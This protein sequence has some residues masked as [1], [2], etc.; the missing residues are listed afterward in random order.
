M[1][2]IRMGGSGA[3]KAK[4]MAAAIG[5]RAP[6]ASLDRRGAIPHALAQFRRSV[7]AFY[8]GQRLSTID[9]ISERSRSATLR[10]VCPNVIHHFFYS[11]LLAMNVYT[12]ITTEA[13]RRIE[14][15]GGFDEYVMSLPEELCGNEHAKMYRRMI[16]AAFV[17]E[18]DSLR[19]LDL[20]LSSKY[21]ED[22]KR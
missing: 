9:R 7:P 15:A 14:R 22:Y 19:K 4:L 16:K 8:H 6:L 20:E 18:R 10:V 5:S 3:K 12:R 13:L 11:R 17:R 1:G 21:G 2:G